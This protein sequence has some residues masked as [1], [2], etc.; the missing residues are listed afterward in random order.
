MGEQAHSL[1]QVKTA[2]ELLQTALPGLGTGGEVHT[3]VIRAINALSRHVPQGAPTV[4]TQQ[5][6]M[7]DLQRNT[8]RNAILQRLQAQQRGPGPMQPSTPVP[9]A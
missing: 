2:V 1:M 5:T 4:G 3:A 8:L 6:M 7:Q 9:G